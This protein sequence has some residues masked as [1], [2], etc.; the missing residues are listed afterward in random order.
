[1]I[2]PLA[3]LNFPRVLAYLLA[4]SMSPTIFPQALEVAS[5]GHYL[6][7]IAMWLP[8]FK[9]SFF[10]TTIQPTTSPNTIF[11]LRRVI[12]LTLVVVSTDPFV[13]DYQ[14]TRYNG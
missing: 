9:L 8:I 5:I 11:F 6:S 7:T 1:M 14:L 13:L 3:N 12:N 2:I 10:D 4:R